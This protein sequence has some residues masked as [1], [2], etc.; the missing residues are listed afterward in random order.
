MSAGNESAVRPELIDHRF[1]HAGH[2]AHVH[3]HVRRIG[4]LDSDLADRRVQRAHGERNHVHR[5]ALHA[6]L[7]QAE[8]LLLHLGGVGP[9]VGRPGLV[10]GFRANEGAIFHAGDVAR[11]RTGEIGAGPLLFVEFDERAALDHQ[12]TEHLVFR[13][14]AIAP[15]NIFRCAEPGHFVHPGQELRVRCC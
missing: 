7:E 13:V 9:I 12:V 6:T 8:Q 14:R 11:V 2:D 10:A 3:D 15:E 4:N 5:A 1:A